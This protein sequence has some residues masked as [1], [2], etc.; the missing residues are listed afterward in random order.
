MVAAHLGLFGVVAA[1]RIGADSLD[2]ANA[3][4]GALAAGVVGVALGVWAVA[5]VGW[6]DSATFSGEIGTLLGND[7]GELKFMRVNGIGAVVL[8]AIGAL[9]I[10]AWRAR[11]REL[12][13]AA[14]GLAALAAL[15]GVLQWRRPV[16]ANDDGGLL[17]VEGGAIALFV[18]LALLLGTAAQRWVTIEPSA[19]DE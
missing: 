14:A 16:G 10:A 12:C 17:G 18:A 3:H 7:W 19:V 1:R 4:R 2:D 11:R 8:L 5:K 9:G 15:L 6:D 13:L